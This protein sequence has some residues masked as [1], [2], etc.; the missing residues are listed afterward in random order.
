MRRARGR[1]RASRGRRAVLQGRCRAHAG[2]HGL[3]RWR[4]ARTPEQAGD[5]TPHGPL[6]FGGRGAWVPRKKESGL[7][8]TPPLHSRA[9]ALFLFSRSPH[10]RTRRNGRGNPLAASPHH[11]AA[12]ACPSRHL[13][14]WR[15]RAAPPEMA[16]ASPPPGGSSEP[17]PDASPPSSAIRS[18]S[19]NILDVQKAGGGL[20][21][22]WSKTGS[23]DAGGADAPGAPP[24]ASSPSMVGTPPAGSVALRNSGEHNH[25]GDGNNSAM[26]RVQSVRDTGERE[27]ERGAGERERERRERVRRER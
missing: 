8:H 9:L 13:T 5:E 22:G 23:C 15:R 7:E 12:R 3:F 6:L 18:R 19:S 14:P 11:R 20:L 2:G 27:R 26:K 16:D 10:P 24:A 25:G 4:P 21:G 1:G 17:P